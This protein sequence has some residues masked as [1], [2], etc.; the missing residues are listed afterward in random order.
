MGGVDTLSRVIIPFS[1][2]RKGLKWYRKLAELFIDIS[3]YNAYIL[4]KKLHPNPLI[5]QNV[6]S[7]ILN[8]TGTYH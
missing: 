2:Q 7:P 3:V 6:V 8:L 4:W 1:V 5:L